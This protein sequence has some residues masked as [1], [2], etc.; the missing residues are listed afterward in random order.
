MPKRANVNSNEGWEILPGW[1]LDELSYADDIALI[2]TDIIKN[3]CRLQ[4]FSKTSEKTATLRINTNKTVRMQVERKENVT[5][6][7]EEDINDQQNWYPC[8]T[9]GR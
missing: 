8:H 3:E 4:N 9:C 1:L 6:T 2:D 7:T 5:K